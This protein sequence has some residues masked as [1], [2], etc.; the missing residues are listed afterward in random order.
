MVYWITGRKG[1]GKTTL[2]WKIASQLIGAVV[3]DADHF[4]KYQDYG[5]T[6]EGRE[7][8]QRSLAAFAKML[9]DMGKIPIIACV[10]PNKKLRKE[11]QKMF[12]NCTEIQL[13]FGELWEGTTYE[14]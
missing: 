2:A 12:D 1:S 5:Y 11:L 3:L 10:S 4:R 7:Q 8:N 6:T 13:P 9:E 14:E